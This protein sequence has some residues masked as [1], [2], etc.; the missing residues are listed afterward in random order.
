[1]SV[2]ISDDL[3]H[4]RQQE[5]RQHAVPEGLLIRAYLNAEL[6]LGEFSERM[7]MS[8]IH[9][10]DWL[11]SHGIATLRAFTDPELEEADERNTQ[12]LSQALG[13]AVAEKNTG[14]L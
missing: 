3:A 10:R 13:I 14:V 9:G 12:Q 4:G 2:E 7:G 1:M 6:S 11:H 5:E 8:Y